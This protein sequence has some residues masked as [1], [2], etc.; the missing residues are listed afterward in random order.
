MLDIINHYF[1]SK[2][3]L[4]FL[5]LIIQFT[6][7]AQSQYIGLENELDLSQQT[8]GQ[9][10]PKSQ[11]IDDY[12][13]VSTPQG[14]YRKDL[15]TINNLTW[16][17]FA[18]SGVP[19][20]DFIKKDNKILANTAYQDEGNDTDSLLIYSS[21]NGLSS[22]YLS[23]PH[24]QQ[25]ELTN[26]IYRIAQNPV[27]LNEI[28]ALHHQGVSRSNDFGITWTSLHDNSPEYQYRF[29]NY[30]PLDT[31][32]IFYTGENG[33]FSSYVQV[34]YD[35]GISWTNTDAVHN[36]A[37][38]YIAFHPINQN[39]L[40]SAG[41][42]RITKSTDK[43]ISW[44]PSF[45]IM[46]YI[47]ICKIIYDKSNPDII[48]AS[49]Y[50]NGSNDSIYILKSVDAGD[51]WSIAY[52]E[53]LENSGGIVDFHIYANKIIFLTRYK[54]IYTLDLNVLSTTNIENK[55]AVVLYPNPSSSILNLRSEH[56]ID[57]VEIFDTNGKVKNIVKP[58]S[59][60]F[61]IDTSSFANGIY[62]FKIYSINGLLLK[63]IIKI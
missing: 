20:R 19:I 31:E 38:H 58:N 34:S 27:N 2:T 61:E 33:F 26:S 1:F 3:Y 18:F 28:L 40:L 62:F 17:S 50:L 13:Y 63:K 8:S 56:Q 21:D 53:P 4:G 36:N 51:N 7:F 30:H 22:N 49:G 55:N 6:T 10:F 46:P 25:P 57:K 5:V 12:I 60:N 42:G 11:I 43:G 16:E 24:F 9:Y 44:N 35:N 39:I 41:E 45:F 32:T 48:Y 59:T 37:T 52:Q 15:S 23:T 29:I 47:Y 54:G 14:I